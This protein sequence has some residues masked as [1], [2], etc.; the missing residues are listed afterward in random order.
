MSKQDYVDERT[1][2]TCQ[3]T[4]VSPFANAP[5]DCP[6]CHGQR[7][8]QDPALATPVNPPAYPPA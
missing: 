5:G 7:K 2:P 6:T 4:G 8:L 3:G 1:C